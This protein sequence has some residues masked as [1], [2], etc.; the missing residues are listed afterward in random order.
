[1]GLGTV[2]HV[3]RTREFGFLLSRQRPLGERL[4]VAGFGDLAS[5]TAAMTQLHLGVDGTQR[6][7]IMAL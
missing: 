3:L 5:N 7:R 4:F 6:G 2:W 1:M